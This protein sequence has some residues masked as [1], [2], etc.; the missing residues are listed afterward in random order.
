MYGLQ[1]LPSLTLAYS[2]LYYVQSQKALLDLE[3]RRSTIDFC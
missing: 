3:Q 2:H 1:D